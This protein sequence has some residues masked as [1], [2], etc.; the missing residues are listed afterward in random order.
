MLEELKKTADG[1]ALLKD[2]VGSGLEPVSTA[3]ANSRAPCCAA[4]EKN[5]T[6][7]WWTNAT[8]LVADAIRKQINFKNGAKL[9]TVLEDKLGTC[10]V[11]LCN[12]SLK[13]WC[14]P[15]H[16]QNHTTEQQLEKFPDW[17]WIK[18]ELSK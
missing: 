11:C 10:S 13:V 7:Q 9:E 15:E 2:W 1:I 4:C 14:P 8:G 6:G 12:L 3:L 5:I 16:I 18:K 17:C